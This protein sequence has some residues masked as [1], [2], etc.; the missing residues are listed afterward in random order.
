VPTETNLAHRVRR[1]SDG[2][3]RHSISKH[4]QS[5]LNALDRETYDVPAVNDKL[6]STS[7]VSTPPAILKVHSQQ[8]SRIVT[9]A[10]LAKFIPVRLIAMAHTLTFNV[11]SP[12]IE[13]LWRFSANPALSSAG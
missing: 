9:Y 4:I 8:L 3:V 1:V 5:C 7:C 12:S 11:K 10:V 6:I 13:P 2:S